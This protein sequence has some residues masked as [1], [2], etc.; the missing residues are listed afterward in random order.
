MDEE[1]RNGLWQACNEFYIRV[2]YNEFEYDDQ[3]R[4]IVE[5]IY[6]YFLK[7]TSDSIPYG[8][9][10]GLGL[11]ATQQAATAFLAT[12]HTPETICGKM[13]NYIKPGSGGEG[14]LILKN[15]G[16]EIV[17]TMLLKPEKSL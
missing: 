2:H 10:P 3:F 5:K 11:N 13:P 16:P 15:T 7:K 8:H 12:R 1:L 17:F 14:L 4:V 6:V 9:A